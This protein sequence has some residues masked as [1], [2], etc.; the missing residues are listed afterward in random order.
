MRKIVLVAAAVGALGLAA[1]SDNTEQAADET[2]DSA[3]ADTEA[4]VDALATEGQEAVDDT[5]DAVD[6]ADAN[7]DAAAADVQADDAA[8]DAPAA[9]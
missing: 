4:N 6:G 7:A 2:F 3:M 9:E 8:Q 5:A 1:C